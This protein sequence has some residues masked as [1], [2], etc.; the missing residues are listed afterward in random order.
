[1]IVNQPD[2]FEVCKEAFDYQLRAIDR[3]NVRLV[4]EDGV[5]K[6]SAENL[7]L[8]SP[9][10]A[11]IV[12]SSQLELITII[13]PDVDKALVTRL[14]NIL[15]NGFT[16]LSLNEDILEM[17]DLTE[18]IKKLAA[19]LGIKLEGLD[20]DQINLDCLKVEPL[21]ENDLSLSFESE[22]EEGNEQQMNNN[23]RPKRIRKKVF[24]E[25]YQYDDGLQCDHCTRTFHGKSSLTA[26]V[27]A[28]HR[29]G[30]FPSSE[31]HL[32]QH[33]K[34]VKHSKSAEK[35]KKYSCVLCQNSF[36]SQ[37][38]L[39]RHKREVQ[40]CKLKRMKIQ[41]KKGK[42]KDSGRKRRKTCEECGKSYSSQRG[43]K[44]H[45]DSVHMGTVYP[46]HV[47][48]KNFSQKSNL[49]AHLQTQTHLLEEFKEKNDL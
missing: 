27:N 39:E 2:Q 40:D 10:L 34:P 18:N 37:S 5:V 35:E 42:K 45:V 47:C 19:Q 33:Q 26:H 24:D 8:F 20:F 46:C 12:A 29:V 22:S 3:N 36:C 16:M 44:V 28:V 43:L 32:Q 6:T 31:D 25:R 15:T 23:K 21:E 14:L 30:Q 49:V 17:G 38:N 9:F 11:D 41:S 48:Q 13:I 4:V 7:L 1:M